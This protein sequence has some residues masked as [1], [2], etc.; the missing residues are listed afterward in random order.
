MVEADGPGLYQKAAVINRGPQPIRYTPVRLRRTRPIPFISVI[1]IIWPVYPSRRLS[2]MSRALEWVNTEKH[3]E[4]L[5]GAY[6]AGYASELAV[7]VL[8]KALK[9]QP[10]SALWYLL[11]TH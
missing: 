10:S 8:E 4:K 6:L 5:V 9:D 7:R 11:G 2:S 1:C 3:Y